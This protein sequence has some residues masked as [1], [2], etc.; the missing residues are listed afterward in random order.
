[1]ATFVEKTG[2]GSKT[3]F[4]FDFPYLETTDINVTVD[5]VLQV[6]TTD[7]TFSNPTTIQFV[8]AP[9]DGAA[10]RIFRDTDIEAKQAT[11]ATGASIRADDLN[12]NFDQ[13]LYSGQ[14]LRQSLIDAFLPDDSVETSMIVDGAVTSAKIADGTIVDADVNAS[15]A[16]QTS[17]LAAGALDTSVT[18]ASANIVDG[19]I[20][21]ADI[22]ASAAIDTSKLAAGALDTSVTVASANIVDGTIVNAD[23]NASAAIDTSKLAAGALDTSVTVASANIVDGTIVDADINASAAIQT[24]K[25]AAGALDTSVTVASANIVDGTIV[26]ADINAA[27]AIDTSKLAA[28]A[29]DTSVTVA[30]AN[31][32]DGTIVDAD[33]NAAAEIALTKLAGGTLPTDITVTTDNIATGTIVSSDIS[34]TAEILVSKLKD[35]DSRQL[36]QTNEVGTGVEWTDNV[37]VPGTLD[38]TGVATFD[39][40]VVCDSTGAL[41]VPDGT[42]AERPVTPATGMIRYNST[43]S[44]YEGYDG[45]SWVSLSTVPDFNDGTAAAPSITFD[46]DVN[47]GLFSAATNELGFTTG[48]VERMRIDSD[49]NFGIRTTTPTEPLEVARLINLPPNAWV[50]PTMPSTATIVAT[51]GNNNANSGSAVCIMAGNTAGSALVFGD[52]DD[53]DVGLIEYDHSDNTLQF[54]VNGSEQMI[55]ES[56]GITRW[57]NTTSGTAVANSL[58]TDGRIQSEATY[59]LTT[60]SAANVHVGTNGLLSRAT[61]SIKYKTDVED[62]EMEFS[63]SIVFNS[64]PVWYRS[65]SEDDPTEYSYWGFIAEEVA[66][67]DPRMVHWGADGQPEG[68]QYERYVVHLVNIIQKQQQQIDALEQ[69]L[70][71]AGI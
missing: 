62:A 51:P 46:S 7:Y 25:L 50:S 70:T 29:L 36:L 5:T 26:N 60:A 9:A 53:G 4:T 2:T 23:I 64:R 39:D 58:V 34:A 11:F 35:G 69:R 3:D 42:T 37:D 49:G 63:E 12:D 55:I 43:D 16:I 6:V 52:S 67:I 41:T 15:A 20:V 66:E 48:G 65:L 57:G 40:Q 30:S 1:M 31:I 54:V 18:V 47:T 17:K 28:G 44:E 8:S 14:E 32:V 24:S 27:A 56:D 38:V 13:I 33:I 22:N 59:T 45:S 71:N 21:N 61:S 19:T 10:I 68:V